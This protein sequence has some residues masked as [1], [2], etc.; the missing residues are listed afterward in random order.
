MKRYCFF[1]LLGM[2]F[3]ILSCQNTG[4]ESAPKPATVQFV[5]K[6]EENDLLERGI[7]AIPEDNG[8]YLEWFGSDQSEIDTYSVY[9]KGEEGSDFYLIDT[10]EDT[11]YIDRNVEIGKRFFYYIIAM[12]FDQQKSAPS[13]TISYK[14]LEKPIRLTPNGS[15]ASNQVTFQWED[16]NQP[17][18]YLIRVQRSDTDETIWAATIEAIYGTEHQ[19]TLFNSDQ[20]AVTDALLSHVPYQWRIDVLGPEFNCGS[21]SS[22]TSFEIE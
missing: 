21:E 2:A 6:S 18:E 17:H 20:A 16:R 3:A 14:L 11:F 19:Q 12:N 8:I 10:V 5:P 13:D 7:D 4:P 15:I 1:L 9:R 22:W